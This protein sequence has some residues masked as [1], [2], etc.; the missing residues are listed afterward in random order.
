M[1]DYD[2][3]REPGLYWVQWNEGDE[4]TIAHQVLLA[5]GFTGLSFY[6][7]WVR[8]GTDEA[9][10]DPIRVL[11][12]PLSFGAHKT[13]RWKDISRSKN[14]PERATLVAA[15]VL[16]ELESEVARLHSEVESLKGS[17]AASR[18]GDPA[19]CPAC[20]A[21]PGHHYG[22]CKLREALA[23][24]DEDVA[25]LAVVRALLERLVGSTWQTGDLGLPR[26]VKDYFK[27]YQDSI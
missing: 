14:D 11:D 12:G 1:N 5:T 18:G 13:H 8:L 21:S 19:R 6:K 4:P 23:E 24:R 17:L 10:R 25:H 27:A 20:Y 16:A 2:V 7:H 26:A 15:K 3:P 22:W 9:T